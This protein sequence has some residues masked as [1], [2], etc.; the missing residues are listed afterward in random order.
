[1]PDDTTAIGVSAAVAFIGFTIPALT[2]VVTP[3][4]TAPSRGVE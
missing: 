3:L 4:V 1:L 2:P